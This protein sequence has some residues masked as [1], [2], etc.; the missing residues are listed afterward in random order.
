MNYPSLPPDD[1]PPSQTTRYDRIL[2]R[3][4]ED[5]TGKHFYQACDRSTQILLSNC[6]WYI[7]TH[8]TALTLVIACPDMVLNWRIL[9]NI[10]EIGSWL[11][12][13][14]SSA[15]IRVCPP[16]SMGT[17]F[18]IRVNEISVYRDSL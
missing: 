18:E 4:L 9:N 6:E 11:E 5:A 7:T 17:P 10:V 13:L 15:K 2:R 16:P 3:K 8:G 12:Q 14:A 1:L